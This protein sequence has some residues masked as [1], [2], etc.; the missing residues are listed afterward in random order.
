MC[1]CR[2][3]ISKIFSVST[4]GNLEVCRGVIFW[5]A[6]IMI[7]SGRVF[8]FDIINAVPFVFVVLRVMFKV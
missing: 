8:L 5:N 3:L 7:V 1:T 4:G 6:I 2:I